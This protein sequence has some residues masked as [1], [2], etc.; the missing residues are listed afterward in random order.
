MAVVPLSISTVNVCF[1]YVF[2]ESVNGSN[3]F[4][5]EEA[6]NGSSFGGL[7]NFKYRN[8]FHFLAGF[9]FD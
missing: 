1:I 9:C 6:Y 3:A 2:G 7:F 8:G 5:S 4:V